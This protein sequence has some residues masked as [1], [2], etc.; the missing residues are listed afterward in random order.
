M[1]KILFEQVPDLFS[2][3]GNLFVEKKEELC[4]MELFP[5]L[6]QSGF[7]PIVMYSGGKTVFIAKEK[8]TR[9]FSTF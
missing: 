3:I 4:E 1:D 5:E 2:S 7:S 9:Y 6:V 8:R